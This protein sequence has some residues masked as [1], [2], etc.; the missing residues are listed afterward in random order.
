MTADTE[1]EGHGWGWMLGLSYRKGRDKR[2][3]RAGEVAGS[4]PTAWKTPVSMVCSFN[5]LKQRQHTVN[6]FMKV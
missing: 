5:S 3:S 2:L 1:G 4:I 6:R